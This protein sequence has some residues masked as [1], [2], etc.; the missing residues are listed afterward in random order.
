[1]LQ[2]VKSPNLIFIIV[3]YIFSI[4]FLF[5]TLG[6][7]SSNEVSTM[8]GPATWPLI[9]L[10]FILV[11]N[12]MALLSTIFERNKVHDA[13]QKEDKVIPNEVLT[14][15]EEVKNEGEEELNKKKQFFLILITGFFILAI[16]LIG[17]IISTAIFFVVCS[18]TFGMRNKWGLIF[19]SI[20]ASVLIH[21]LFEKVLNVPIP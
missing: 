1:M 17:F 6:L 21:G 2:K 8:S 13:Q 12:T 18:Y 19:I 11:L 3:I 9:L 20:L 15:V 16:N 7:P 4:I 14:I 5:L 10:I